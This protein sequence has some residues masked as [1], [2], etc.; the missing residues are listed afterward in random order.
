MGISVSEVAAVLNVLIIFI[1][2][3]LPLFVALIA[4]AIVENTNNAA[5]WCVTA[6][7]VKHYHEN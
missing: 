2:F 4:V 6:T 3:T 7:T 5:T 1:Q